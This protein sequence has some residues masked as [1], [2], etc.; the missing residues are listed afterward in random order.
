MDWMT[1]KR[2]VIIRIML[3]RSQYSKSDYVFDQALSEDL[4]F[5]REAGYRGVSPKLR[6]VTIIAPII[7]FSSVFIG[8]HVVVAVGLAMFAL[9]I[10]L[11]IR[12]NREGDSITANCPQ[13]DTEMNKEQECS[14]EY[15]V[16]HRCKIYAKGR[17]WS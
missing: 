6:L 14:I 2:S 4:Q 16:C 7:I 17:D 15:F 3:L 11:I 12:H 1:E 9:M 13:C 10:L 8:F 5:R